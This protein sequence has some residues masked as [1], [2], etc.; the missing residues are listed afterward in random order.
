MPGFTQFKHL[1]PGIKRQK[2]SFFL[3]SVQ[4]LLLLCQGFF[5]QEDAAG[6]FNANQQHFVIKQDLNKI[7]SSCFCCFSDCCPYHFHPLPIGEV[8]LK[9]SFSPPGSYFTFQTDAS[10]VSKLS[11]IYKE[12]DIVYSH[13]QRNK[14]LDSTANLRV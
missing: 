1:R 9:S 13:F 2:Y 7:S 5:F 8:L 3:V 14:A 11:S 4:L 12:G 10:F 6:I